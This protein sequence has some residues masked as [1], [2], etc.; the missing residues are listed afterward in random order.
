MNLALKN[1]EVFAKFIDVSL[2]KE[3]DTLLSLAMRIASSFYSKSL[4]KPMKISCESLL[5]ILN[6]IS[7]NTP[8][9]SFNSS[10]L[11]RLSILSN[12]RIDWDLLNPSFYFSF[13]LLSL[14]FEIYGSLSF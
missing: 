12:F 1:E 4:T 13:S 14:K 10:T 7:L 9:R 3:K 11:N 8:L 6:S 2:D 5:S